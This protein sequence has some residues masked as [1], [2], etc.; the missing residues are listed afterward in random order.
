MQIQISIQKHEAK[1]KKKVTSTIPLVSLISLIPIAL[2]PTQPFKTNKE[3]SHKK[4]YR[5]FFHLISFQQF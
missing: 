4:I 2:L 5:F 1:K 3:I